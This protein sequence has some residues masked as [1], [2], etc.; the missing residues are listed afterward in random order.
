MSSPQIKT[1]GSVSG[2]SVSQQSPAVDKR[3][4]RAPLPYSWIKAA[5]NLSG[6]ALQVAMA[7]RYL[8]GV[9]GKN[10]IKLSHKYPKDFGVGMKAFYSALLNLE[11]AKLIAVDRKVG[12]SPIVTVLNSQSASN[13]ITDG[14]H[15]PK[16]R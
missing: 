5:A 7:I 1:G 16:A 15:V 4:I 3:F 11:Q 12:R 2:V 10:T 6:K 9:S 14:E 8:V 13:S